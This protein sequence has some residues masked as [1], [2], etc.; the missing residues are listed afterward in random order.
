MLLSFAASFL[1]IAIQ[2]WPIP[3]TSAMIGSH[4]AIARL[5]D[6]VPEPDNPHAATAPD[7][8]PA[9]VVLQPGFT[10]AHPRLVVDLS[11]RR[12]YLRR[13]GQAEESFPIAVGQAGWETP[14]GTFKVVQM[15]QD[16]IWRHPI[17]KE[18]VPPGPK[19]PLGHRW[20]GF[21]VDGEH[22]IG[23]HGTNQPDL[24]GQAVSH[25]CIR[26]YNKDIESLYDQVTLNTPVLVQP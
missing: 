19:N 14:T 7:A 22:Q 9:V 17:T 21:W 20:I 23:F 4:G 6:P 3:S 10:V 24:V 11:D 5:N 8:L 25:G 26:M 18:L 1:L 16:P 2:W 13:L 15:Q 12:V